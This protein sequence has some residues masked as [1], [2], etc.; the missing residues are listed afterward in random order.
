M[1]NWKALDVTPLKVAVMLVC[2][3]ATV[4]ARPPATVA[5]PGELDVHVARLVMLALELS[6]YLPVA[7]NCSLLL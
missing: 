1:V 5:T 2:P 4:V 7:V 3:A 6:L